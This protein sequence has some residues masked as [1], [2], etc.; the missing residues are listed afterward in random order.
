MLA[1]F[2]IV[3]LNPVVIVSAGERGVVLNWGAVSKD[4]LDE[5]IH[6]RVPFMQRVVNINV[7]TQALSIENSQAYSK[8]LQVV[9]IHS[10]LNYAVN[11]GSAGSLYQHVGLDYAAKIVSPRLEGAVKQTIA[12]FTAEQLLSSRGEVQIEIENAV[13]A[14]LAGEGIDVLK[15]TLVNEEFSD[16]YEQAI[17]RKQVAEQDALAAKN[18]LEQVQFEANQR[19]TSAK[20]EAEAIKIQTESIA[21][22]GGEAYVQLKAIERWDGRLPTQYVPNTSLPLINIK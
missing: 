22:N 16:E 6:W 4:I 11:P 17:E 3:T 20:A 12:Q 7:Q 21:R 9:L 18:K 5:G 10:V 1:L 2:V 14:A 13:K 8:N 19:V 15:Y